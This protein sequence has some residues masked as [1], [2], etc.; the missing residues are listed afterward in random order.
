MNKFRVCQLIGPI[1]LFGATVAAEAAAYGLSCL[2][3]SEWMWYLNL[4]WFGMFQQSHYALRD[5]MGIDC[6]QL[7]V[8]AL[9]L[10]VAAC[11]GI[12]LR[13]VLLLAVAS[14]LTFVYMAFVFCAWSRA[15][16]FPQ[17]AS[18]SAGF[19]SSPAIWSNPDMILL[20]ILAGLSL[21]SFLASHAFYLLNTRAII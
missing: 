9:P 21:F 3:S 13:R 20:A 6:E 1:A 2:P 16:P 4:R 14:N 18:L 10:L 8:I 11:L 17:T 12:A 5:L 15:R 7:L 19:V